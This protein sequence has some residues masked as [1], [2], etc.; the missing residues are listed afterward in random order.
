MNGNTANWVRLD[1]VRF[2]KS[3]FSEVGDCVEVAKVEGVVVRD[4]KNPNGPTL[5]FTIQEWTAF[6]LGVLLG[7]FDLG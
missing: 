7:E 1:G 6:V 5:W 3:S 4:S 2:R